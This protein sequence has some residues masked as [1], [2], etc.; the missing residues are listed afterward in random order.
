VDSIPTIPLLAPEQSR[1]TATT[2]PTPP[3]ERLVGRATAAAA[4]TILEA[5]AEYQDRG[6][7]PAIK[8]QTGDAFWQLYRLRQLLVPMWDFD[9][10]AREHGVTLL[11]AADIAPAIAEIAVDEVLSI[12]HKVIRDNLN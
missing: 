5:L 9:V 8:N 7:S 1:S 4:G 11:R 6:L 2:I 3:I 10:I 12:L